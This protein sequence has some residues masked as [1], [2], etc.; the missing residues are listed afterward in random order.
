MAEQLRVDFTGVT[1]KSISRKPSSG[2]EAKFS[3]NLTAAVQKKMGWGEMPPYETSAN[4]EGDLAAQSM[5]LGA[6]D[7][8]MAAYEI[9]VDIQSAGG[10]EAIRK[11]LP[12]K[13]A[14]GFRHVLHFTV[15]FADNA[16]GLLEEYMLKVPEEKGSM[17]ILY[18]PRAAQADLPQQTNEQRQATLAEND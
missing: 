5:I 2:G 9:S 1:L 12:G 4:L 11:E 10:F 8:L 18:V 13:R 17:T 7:T 15:K 3:A 16:M 6:K 14:K